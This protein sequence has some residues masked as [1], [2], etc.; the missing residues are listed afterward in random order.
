MRVSTLICSVLLAI[1][2]TGGAQASSTL[3]V[4]SQV[5]VA[6]DSAA[7]V[8]ALLGKPSY[9]AHRRASRSKGSGRRGGVRVVTQAQEGEQ[10]QYRRGGHVTTITIID[11]RVSDI[12]E[13]RR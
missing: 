9:T 12:Q 10:W 13:R 1:A 11:G 6:G 7:R 4:G 2:C 3:R 8:T 5:L